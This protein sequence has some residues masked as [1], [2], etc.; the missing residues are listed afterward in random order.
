M[1]KRF[2]F[3]IL[4]VF[5]GLIALILF[6][7]FRFSK[8]IP[9]FPSAA[10]TGISDSA[11]VHLSR[12]IQIK[13]VSFGDTLAID[14]TEFLKFR[15]F[16]E[17][18]YPA[19][20]QKLPRQIIS[21]FSYI[22]TWVGKNP[23][24]KPY[25]IMAHMDVVPVE[26]IA[27]KNWTVPSFSGMIK[28]D[29]IWGRGAVDDKASAIAIFEAA[30]QL[31]NENFQ[32]ERTIY[33]CFGH[34]EEISGKRGAAKIADWF[35][36]Q[37][38]QPE[39]VLD[40][41]GQVDTEHFPELKR[42]VAVIG[43]GEKGY[44]NIDLVV[45]KP[46]GHSSMPPTETAIDILNSAIEKVRLK[47]MPARI[48]DPVHQMFQRIGPGGGFVNRMALS[49]QWLFKE[50]LMHQLEKSKETNALIHTTLVPTIV[51][52]GIKDNVIPSIAK[53]TFNSRILPGE[54]SEDVLA[55][56]K[57]AINDER[58]TVT[59]QPISL[60][61]PSS[62]TSPEHPMFKKVE[63]ITYQTVPN[64]IVTPYLMV[65]ATDSRYFRSFSDAVVNFAPMT[66][67]KGFH[68]IDERIPISDLHRMIF[69][70]KMLITEK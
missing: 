64:A 3:A 57:K 26:A 48:T 39:L 45:E 52:A 56:V 50:L 12:A 9:V 33:L 5:L 17:T 20:H 13:T 62:A 6:N 35:K 40:E 29:T 23:S 51:K 43:V 32:P 66:N 27:E 34:D 60:M 1:F 11:A 68:G 37:K 30:E 69:F 38:I 42:P 55:F 25:I 2:L 67:A 21:E 46:G 47:Q 10:V 19:I 44:V 65:G 59:K 22:Y 8:T 14:T 24:L 61:E 15:G 58:V 18:T 70:Y 63:R 54:T 7:T 16:L 28:G 41:G 36:E 49:N 4:F 31:L 53:A